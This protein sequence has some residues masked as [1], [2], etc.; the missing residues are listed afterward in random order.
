MICY[1][2]KAFCKSD[3]VHAT[4]TRR[5]SEHD[6]QKAKEL[7]LPVAWIDFRDRCD[8]YVGPDTICNE[9]TRYSQ[10]LGLYDDEFLAKGNPL[11]KK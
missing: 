1:K 11:V 4:C 10:E 9:M 7:G 2:D 8:E 6:E 3:C 5:F